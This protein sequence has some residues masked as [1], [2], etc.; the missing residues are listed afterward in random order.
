MAPLS[1]LGVVG[2]HG[3]AREQKIRPIRAHPER[4]GAAKLEVSSAGQVG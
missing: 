3:A 1:P 2:S 4:S